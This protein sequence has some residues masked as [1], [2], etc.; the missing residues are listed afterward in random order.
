MILEKKLFTEAQSLFDRASSLYFLFFNF[1]TEFTSVTRYRL[2]NT[3]TR[4]RALDRFCFPRSLN[5]SFI[6]VVPIIRLLDY[7]M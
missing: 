4:F 1:P 3:W 6:T 7:P 2:N 5:S